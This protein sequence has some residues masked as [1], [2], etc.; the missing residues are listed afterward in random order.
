MW[1]HGLG[2]VIRSLLPNGMELNALEEYAYSPYKCFQK[3]VEIAPSKYI[4]EHLD[5]KI[6]MVYS[7]MATQK[8]KG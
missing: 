3:T 2:E 8:S 6:P 5:D 4:I 1:N 7:L